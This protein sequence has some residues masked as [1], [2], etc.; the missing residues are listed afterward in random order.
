M[1]NQFLIIAG[2]FLA[3]LAHGQN[4]PATVSGQPQPQQPAQYIQPTMQQPQQ[5]AQQR[6]P[7]RW[8]PESTEW[9][10]PVPVKVTPGVGTKPPSDAIVLF[11][12]SDLSKWQSQGGG[13][14][15][16][17]VHDGVFTVEPGTGSISTKEYF[18]DCQLHIEF[19]SPDPENYHGQNRGNSGIMIQS[20]YEVQVLDG[21]NNPT[22]VNGMVGSIYKQSAP[23]VNAY[24]KNGE[25][26]VYD[27]FWTAPRFGADDK[28]ESPAI[29]TVVLNGIVVQNNYILKGNT[30]Y[31]GLPRYTAHGRMPLSLQDHNTRVSFRN[32]WIRNL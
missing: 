14:A 16:W 4:P 7:E 30:P 25:W 24:T 11:D 10:T 32:I 15:K 18:G 22:Y 8:A 20:R 26:Q 9:Y 27:I 12:G 23:L 29:I 28:L 13:P 5:A 17:K 1:K 21:D 2:L 6:Q 31:T 19:K 3:A